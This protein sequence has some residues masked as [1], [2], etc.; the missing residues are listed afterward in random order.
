MS[1]FSGDPMKKLKEITSSIQRDFKYDPNLIFIDSFERISANLKTISEMVTELNQNDAN[2]WIIYNIISTI[3]PI[4]EKLIFVGYSDQILE[5]LINL[6]REVSVNLI[7]I[8]SRFVPLR[9]AVFSIIC[10][11]YSNTQDSREKDADVFI[12]QFKSELLQYKQ[13]EESNISGLTEKLTV[14][15]GETLTYEQLYANSFHVIDLIS[16]HFSGGDDITLDNST[17]SRKQDRKAKGKPQKKEEPTQQTPQTLPSQNTVEMIANAFPDKASK[18]DYGT[19]YGSVITSWCNP[20]CNF[21]ANLLHR[22]LFAFMR[23]KANVDSIEQLKEAL[24]EDPIVKITAAVQEKNWVTIG[25]ILSQLTKEQIAEDLVFFNQ[26]AAYIWRK[27]SS[28]DLKETMPLKGTLNVYVHSP[29]PCPLQTALVALKL[30]WYLDGEKRSDEAAQVAEDALVVIENFRDIFSTRKSEKILTTSRIPSKPLDPNFIIFEKWLSCLH[31]D[32]LTILIRSKL[33]YGLQCDEVKAKDD[34]E[35]GIE[36]LKVQKEKTKEIYGTLSLKQQAKFEQSINKQFKPPVHAEDVEKE[37]LD[38]FKSNN[39]AKALLYIQMSFFRPQKAADFLRKACELLQEVTENE[40]SFASPIIYI[41]RTEAAFIYSGSQQDAKQVALFG[42]EAV[43]SSGLTLQNTALQG[44]GIKQDKIEPFIVTNL[45]PNTKYIF[46]FAAYDHEGEVIDTITDNFTITTTHPLSINLIWCYI[47][48]A[49]YQL[50]DMGSFDTSLSTLI[51]TYSDVCERPV[52]SQFYKD[53]N[54][55]NR[56]SLKSLT[57]EEP[58][59]LLQALSTSLMMAARVFA[60]KPLHAT[61]FHKLALLLSQV[62]QN[63]SLT[64]QICN[65]MFTILQPVLENSFHSR[66]VIH[67]LLFI[68]SALK[69]NKQTQKDPVHQDIIARCAFA[70]DSAFAYLYQERQLS[71]FVMS[72][73]LELPPNPMRTS[74]LMFASRYHLLESNIGDSTLPLAAADLFRASPEKAHDDLF[75]KFKTDPSY[76]MA[77]TYLVANAHNDGLVTQGA[78]WATT[79]LDYVK[80]QLSETEEK[81]QAKKG[82]KTKEPQKQTKPKKQPAKKDKKGQAQS[83]VNST[84]DLQ[85]VQ[86]ATKIQTVYVR[87]NQR[88]KNLKKFTEANKYRAALNMLQ[89]MCMIEQESPFA[90]PT[91]QQTERSKSKRKSHRKDKNQPEDDAPASV[92]TVDNSTQI[93]NLIRRSIVLA[94]RVGDQIIIRNSANLLRDYLHS[95]PIGCSIVSGDVPLLDVVTHLLIQILPL[96]EKFAQLLLQ[97]LILTLLQNNIKKNII[98]H[99]LL[100]TERA[101]S[102]GVLLWLLSGEELP[103]QL[104]EVGQLTQR[105]DPAENLFYHASELLNKV[106]PGRQRLFPDDL[107]ISDLDAM[108]KTVDDIA[109]NLQHKQRLTMSCTLLRRLAFLHFQN[110]NNELATQK[111]LEALECHFRIVHVHEKINQILSDKTEEKFYQEFSWSGCISIFTISSLLAMTMDRPHAMMLSKLASFA[112]SA[113]FT[114]NNLNPSKAIDYAI[115]EPSEIISGID[116]FSQFDPQ[117]PLLEPIP[118]DYLTLAISNHLSSL[119]SYEMY[120]EMFKPLAFARHYYRFIIRD[121]RLLTRVR[122]MAVQTCAEYGLIK[123]AVEILSNVVTNFGFTRRTREYQPALAT[124]KRFEYNEN[125]PAFSTANLDCIKQMT[126]SQL[127]G[128]LMTQFGLTLTSQYVIAISKVMQCLY[129]TNDPEGN[130]ATDSSPTQPSAHR[131][132]KKSHHSSKNFTASVSQSSFALPPTSALDI[133]DPTVKTATQL[134]QEFLNKE[135]KADQELVK[136]ELQLELGLLKASQWSWEG[137]IDA[138]KEVIS[139]VDGYTKTEMLTPSTLSDRPLLLPCGMTGLAAQLIGRSAYNI[140]DHITADRYGSPYTK[141]LVYI[142]KADVESA[143]LLLAQ[144]AVQKPVT[145]FY[146]EYIL[147]CGQLLVLYCYNHKLVDICAPRVPHSLRPKI[148]PKQ[149]VAQLNQD[150]SKFYSEQLGLKP[151]NNRYIRGTHLIIRLMHLDALVQA[152]FGSSSDSVVIIQNAIDAMRLK[153]PYIS[154]GLMY[155][156]CATSAAIQVRA[157]ISNH[158][159]ALQFWNQEI[160]PLHIDPSQKYSPETVAALKLLI[161][162]IFKSNPDCVIHPLSNQASLDLVA[163]T[164]LTQTDIDRRLEESLAALKMCAV[165]RSA[166]RFIQSFIST[167]LDIPPTNAPIKLINDN[168]DASLRGLAAAYYSHIMEL[169]LPIFDTSLLEDRTSYFFKCFE[170]QCS[171]FK[172]QTHIDA[173]I[174]QGDVAAQWYMLDTRSMKATDNTNDAGVTTTIKSMRSGVSLA[175]S[176]A[177]TT[178]TSA[179]QSTT[180]AARKKAANLLRG[181]VLFC[182]G[183]VVE[184]EESKKKRNDTSKGLVPFML[185]GQPNELKAVS[186]ELSGIGLDLEEAKRSEPGETQ[187]AEQQ[188]EAAD[189]KSKKQAS[190]PSKNEQQ[191]SPKAPVSQLLKETESKWA[192]TVHK[193]QSALTKSARLLAGI[194]PKGSTFT[195]ELHATNLDINAA[196]NLSKLFNQQLGI[197]EKSSTQISDWIATEILGTTPKVTQNE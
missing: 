85:S 107:S 20:E 50:R 131:S 31:T 157:F 87:Y 116:I 24:P 148:Q 66:W 55:F 15:T 64:L 154:H 61:A 9:M 7:L 104:I 129:E 89:A 43:N 62:L 93:L 41:N 90:L 173:Q 23:C 83:G 186:D 47:A 166:A 136:A 165:T 67:P 21:S 2:Y 122:L 46:G 191:N 145:Q 16:I 188:K 103:Q 179:T 125:E 36:T 197:C 72:C 94:E 65:E 152:H 27:Y 40:M 167:T 49:A 178:T 34:F 109:I 135:F 162:S 144:I 118:A 18:T 139:I 32:V 153:C 71:V 68:M 84:D 76:L 4:C 3:L 184:S 5:F 170:E 168:K 19:R 194:S 193:A 114:G 86:A 183:I 142:H 134:V 108:I 26:L 127:I 37:L 169:S 101:P 45:K 176:I 112:I 160:N 1:S 143:A 96:D 158:P 182:L 185:A 56:F 161:L 132:H 51:A 69:T 110:G 123:F 79:A 187:Q 192:M 97:D 117:Q 149:L 102:C 82:A 52:E 156:L 151:S 54:P 91:A 121:S 181:N 180:A 124:V 88:Q 29:S 30:A 196:T 58:A 39:M 60:E 57:Y 8:T 164:G 14:C 175:T 25:E 159:T 77:A 120:F 128:N 177:R 11:A 42:K 33:N 105:R 70:L 28:G 195:A 38:R 155:L 146:R 141:A 12:S 140:H 59:P 98:S 10:S 172:I 17:S 99:M 100:A 174:E 92:P 35:K 73:I 63:Q 111:L 113:L 115:Y 126:S 163:L 137:A 150:V 138:G 130:A 74:F 6:Y 13:L 189:K 75:N 171:S 119:L 80:S 81:N 78:A 22:L 53:T 44:T 133:F 106:E 147:A 48:S 95:L 190:K